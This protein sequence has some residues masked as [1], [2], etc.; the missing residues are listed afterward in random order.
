MKSLSPFGSMAL[1]P[2]APTVQAVLKPIAVPHK[3][4]A[5]LLLEFPNSLQYNWIGLRI[6]VRSNGMNPMDVLV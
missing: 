4:S 1:M 6:P 3:A 5:F 2:M